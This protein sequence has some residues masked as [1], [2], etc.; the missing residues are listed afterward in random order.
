MRAI[1]SGID[2][3]SGKHL[4]VACKERLTRRKAAL[5]L[6]GDAPSRGPDI[7]LRRHAG[8]MAATFG[9][10]NQARAPSIRRAHRDAA[11]GSA[12]IYPLTTA[13]QGSHEVSLIQYRRSDWDLCSDFTATRRGIKVGGRAS[14]QAQFDV[15]AGRR[16]QDSTIR[17]HEAAAHTAATRIAA[18]FS[19][20]TQQA[21]ISAR[22][23]RIDVTPERIRM[24]G[25]S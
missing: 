21:D 23:I 8:T 17:A 7:D 11:S 10:V 4:R 22:G 25:T 1:E 6:A 16:G 9:A 18:D 15:A 19:V 5:L 3:D 14:R 2:F 24:N 13:I 20:D 12:C